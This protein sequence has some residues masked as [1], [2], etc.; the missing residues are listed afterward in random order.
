MYIPNTKI[1]FRLKL[2]PAELEAHYQTVIHKALETAAIREVGM[3][4]FVE[5]NQAT[6]TPAHYVSQLVIAAAL[7]VP[8]LPEREHLIMSIRHEYFWF[9]GTKQNNQ[10]HGIELKKIVLDKL[11]RKAI[12]AQELT[13]KKTID[14]VMHLTTHKVNISRIMDIKPLNGAELLEINDK[15]VVNLKNQSYPL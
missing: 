1:P 12:L 10:Q 11:L 9:T 3:D 4:L 15:G 5:E 6:N 2:H 7:C 14:G 13:V 8:L